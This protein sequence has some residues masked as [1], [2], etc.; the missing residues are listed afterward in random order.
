MSL[1]RFLSLSLVCIYMGGSIFAGDYVLT[2]PGKA[3]KLS[4]NVGDGLSYSV[5]HKD[6]VLMDDNAL[7]LELD[8]MTL[9]YKP[10]VRKVSRRYAN[11]RITAF[12]YRCG[13]FNTDYNELTMSFKGGYSLVFRAYDEG[14]AY[15]WQTELNDS[16]IIRN[17][18]A[19]FN[20]AEDYKVYLPHTTNSKGDQYAMAFQNIYSC[21]QLSNADN[22][23]VAF[24][25]V[26]A[27]CGNGVKIT[28]LESDL[29]SYPGMFIRANTDKLAL[30]GEF[31]G[32]P[33][34]MVSR[35]PRAMTYVKHRHDYIAR[36]VGKRTYPWRIMAI[37]ERDEDMPVNNMVYALASPNR[38]GDTSWIQG[39]KVA[40]DWWSDWGLT[41]VNFKAGINMDTYKHYIDFAAENGLE[42]VVLD[43]GWYD[44]GKGDMLTVVP[45]LD[46]PELVDYGKSKGVNLILWAVFNV[47]DSQL[48][49]A[50]RK[51]SAMGISG[52]KIDFLDRD[53]QTAVEMLYRIAET[54]AK[55]HLTLDLH[56]FYKPTGVNRTY[57]HIINFESVFGMEE[58][59]WST[60]D[61][62]M[63]EYDVTMPYIRMMAGPVDYTPGAMRNATRKDFKPI[64]YNPMSQGTRCHQLAAYIVHDSPLTMLSDTPEAYRKERECLDFISSVPNTNIEETRVLQGKVGEYIVVAR[65]VGENWYIGGMTDWNPREI[66]LDLSFLSDGL[67]SSELFTDGK[68]AGKNA[69][70]YKK[71][72][73]ILHAGKE[74]KIS[75]AP[76]GGFAMS[77]KHKPLYKG[78]V[79]DTLDFRLFVAADKATVDYFGGRDVYQK[80]LD[81]AFAKVNRKWNGYE[82]NNFNH[83]YRFIPYLETVYTGSSI[84]AGND[85]AEKVNTS[86]YDLLFFIDGKCDYPDEKGSFSCGG[87]S[88]GLTVVSVKNGDSKS[89]VKDFL[90]DNWEGFAH[91]L[92]HYRGVT[93][94]YASQ[95]RAEKNPVNHRSYMPEKCLMLYSSGN[96]TWSTYAVNIINM[97]ADSKQLSKDYPN[98]FY[99]LFPSQIEVMVSEKGK[100]VINADVRIYGTRAVYYDVITPAYRTYRTDSQGICIINK[101]PDIYC[102]P[103]QPGRPDDLPWGRWFGLI[104]EVEYNNVKKYEWLPEYKVQNITF[105]GK[106]TYTLNF[107]F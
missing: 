66:V 21:T 9:G 26:T 73:Q 59:K 43:E 55:Y 93:D 11:E 54:T 15:R 28:L 42:F 47:L 41:G 57:P 107:D 30:Q 58:M 5:F 23:T 101:V 97:T 105:E 51:Y 4:L 39:G 85:V 52:F 40:W 8:D 81:E 84:Q 95:V 62:D 34:E 53:D 56:G 86:K 29:E 91:E 14:I 77:L 102:N 103:P 99:E 60:V 1:K 63:M 76:E 64:Y 82:R 18:K 65:R 10:S 19:E 92:G 69:S 31:A 72:E 90:R 22:K 100:P 79:A 7:S 106:D 13:G 94:L 44:P 49:A 104:V 78:T 46:L 96:D 32:Y 17:E 61:K 83:Y 87:N 35:P 74:L 20:F 98:L 24:L 70:D 38:I 25:P 68:N 27:D 2:S 89:G 88:K 3:L 48:E 36:T 6:K 37:T 50:C 80:K 75:M 12:N 45:E 71:T 33:S 16:I 67:Y